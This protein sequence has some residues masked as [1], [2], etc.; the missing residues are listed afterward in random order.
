M[1]LVF[2]IAAGLWG[3]GA[4]MGVPRRSRLAVLGGLF[5]AH[6]HRRTTLDN[7]ETVLSQPQKQLYDTYVR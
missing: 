1:L 6:Y 2:L 4:F 7:A 5:R 3:G